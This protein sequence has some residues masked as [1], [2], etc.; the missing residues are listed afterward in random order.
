MK[1]NVPLSFEPAS[2]RW[3]ESLTITVEPADVPDA[4]LYLLVFERR[5]E[6]FL[7]RRIP[8]SLD[9]GRWAAHIAVQYLSFEIGLS[10]AAPGWRAEGEHTIPIRNQKGPAP[11]THAWTMVR[12]PERY[13]ELIAAE[14]ELG[15][16][17]SFAQVIAWNVQL[18][19]GVMT[20]DEIQAE[21]LAMASDAHGLAP[22]GRRAIAYGL[23]MSGD[24]EYATRAIEELARRYPR[25]PAVDQA[26]RDQDVVRKTL[27]LETPD[28]LEAVRERLAHRDPT[29]PVALERVARWAHGD[30]AL[31]TVQRIT[32]PWISREPNN[33]LPYH[34]VALAL[35]RSDRD[36]LEAERASRAAL[37]RATAGWLWVY[38]DAPTRRSV[39]AVCEG[40]RITR[41]HTALD[42]GCA[43]DALAH[44]RITRASRA[45]DE[46]EIDSLEAAA[47]R[48][49]QPGATSRPRGNEAL[50]DVP[51]R[52]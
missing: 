2:P 49:L 42:S 43:T 32:D 33:P 21:A 27:G 25:S 36:P 51:T 31:P 22:W 41:V 50:D 37:D 8:M 47:L 44:L 45:A 52:L 14:K 46:E 23:A 29:R 7:T 17:N 4:P 24:L 39:E 20:A 13:L 10:L 40:M 19:L 38:Y 6:G 16:H 28:P 3:G 15:A 1:P 35:R 18:Q 11:G 9:S 12:H 34:Y 30:G 26:L 48:L 5:T